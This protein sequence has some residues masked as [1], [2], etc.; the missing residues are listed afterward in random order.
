MTAGPRTAGKPIGR[1]PARRRLP[2]ALLAALL[3]LLPAILLGAVLAAAPAQAQTQD[4]PEAGAGPLREV[5]ELVT[6]R[7][8]VVTANPLAA[9]AGLELLRAG[10]N[11]VDAAAAAALALNVVEPQSSGIGGGA[12]LLLALGGE[13][14]VLAFDG[15]AEAPAG[16]TPGQFLRADGS[17]Q[18]F[19]PDRITGG[20]PVGVPGLVKLLDKV[21]ARHGRLGLAR[22]VLPAIRLAEEGFSVSPRLARLL[23]LQRE[24]LARFP[25]TRAVLLR[26]D[27]SAWQAGDRLR[28]PDLAKALRLIGQRGAE[29]FYAGPLAEAIVRAVNEAPVNPGRMSLADLAGYEAPER[30]PVTIAYRGFTLY[31]MG[32]P[33]SGGVAIFQL[34]GLLE[35]RRPSAAGQ[36]L[37]ETPSPAAQP[38]KVGHPPAEPETSRAQSLPETPPQSLLASESAWVHP[39]VQASRLAFADRERYVADPDFVPVPLP[40]LLDPGYLHARA[41]ALDWDAPL[42]P[43]AAGTPPGAPPPAGAGSGAEEHV[44]T[45]HLVVVDGERNVVSLTASIE[46]AFGSGM[47]VPGWGFLLNNELTDFNAKPRDEAGRPVANR[48]DGERRARASALDDPQSRGGKRPRSSMAPTIVFQQGRPVLAL[49]SPGGPRII[50]YVALTLLRALDGRRSLQSAIAAPLVVHGGGTTVLE[51]E[52]GPALKPALEKLGHRVEMGRLGSGLHGIWIA[53]DGRLHSGVDPRRE[54]SAAGY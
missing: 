33:G 19:Y 9:E 2:A 6:D 5:A 21:L 34:L 12:F 54:G 36:L 43:A 48:V 27:G 32:P 42:G 39:F 11:A 28:Q 22:A 52:W 37:A 20:R 41:R 15:R 35:A 25:A 38:P 13:E 10:G 16:A 47:I 23:A 44:S 51:P 46:Q 49:G 40:G 24:R 17:P 7:A 50:P 31:G 8:M 53:P 29:A 30:R 45:T 3:A 1:R 18:P 4:D 26:P 14:R